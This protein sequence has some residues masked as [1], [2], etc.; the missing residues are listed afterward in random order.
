MK[1]WKKIKLILWILISLTSVFILV[2]SLNL[3]GF[4]LFVVKSGSMEPQIKVGSLVV[5]RNASEYA[6]GDVVTF[7]I[8][9]KEKVTHRIQSVEV[10]NNN[11][12]YTVKGDAND[13]PD[14]SKIPKKNVIGKV[15]FSIPYLGY[16]IAYAKSLPGL[17]LFIIVPA[18]II[19]YEEV[20]KINKEILAYKKKI[21]K[22]G[23]TNVA[24]A[25]LEDTKKYVNKVLI[26][27]KKFGEE[28]S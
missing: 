8:S 2:T 16:L 12:Y 26:K 27:I 25:L 17:I 9:D 18:T 14:M 15:I 4:R 28:R 13:S 19:I 23:K 1:I 5:D 7:L 21:K 11:T 24:L 22:R 20:G 3:F 10:I 6:V